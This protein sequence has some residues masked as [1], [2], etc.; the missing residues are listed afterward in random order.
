MPKAL[1]LTCLALVLAANGA[2][3]ADAPTTREMAPVAIAREIAPRL[4]ALDAAKAKV[5]YKKVVDKVGHLVEDTI[6]K[7]D[8]AGL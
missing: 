1:P 6:Q 8:R 2:H 5:Y 4:G 7:W 3:A